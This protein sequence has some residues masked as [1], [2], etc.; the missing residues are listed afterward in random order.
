MSFKF[1]YNNRKEKLDDD[2]DEDSL[3]LTSSAGNR[4]F[5]G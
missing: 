5:C 3:P 4:I 2:E 1:I